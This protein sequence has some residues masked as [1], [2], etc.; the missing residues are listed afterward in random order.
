[1]PSD[2]SIRSWKTSQPQAGYPDWWPRWRSPDVFVDNDGDALES[3]DGSFKYYQNVDEIGEP[4]KG[5]ERPNYLNAVVRNLGTSPANEVKVK[6]SYAPYGIVSGTLYQHVHFKEIK[7]VWV[8]LAPV[9]QPNAEKR[10]EVEWDLRNLSENNGGLWPA[11]IGFFDHFC[12]R[13]ELIYPGD[14]NPGNNS[15]QHNFA[16][17]PTS[18]PAAPIYLLASNADDKEK[19]VKFSANATKRK[20]ALRVRGLDKAK[21]PFSVPMWGP[22]EVMKTIEKR[23]LL[24]ELEAKKSHA[25]G[26][27]IL[28]PRES[29]LITIS[30]SA[31]ELREKQFIELSFKTDGEEVGGVSLGIRK[32]RPGFRRLASRRAPYVPRGIVSSSTP[33]KGVGLIKGGRA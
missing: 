21:A 8:N 4:I 19:S 33:N 24:S 15:T 13:V 17:I 11:P 12:V 16:N 31:S 3:W 30:I 22:R 28:Q 14:A 1:M 20:S 10:V 9:G 25:L 23:E 2:P 27:L 18:S 6:F 26:S 7:S 29:K 32:A 5:G